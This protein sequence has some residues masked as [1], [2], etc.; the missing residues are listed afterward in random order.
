VQDFLQESKS[1]MVD[2]ILVVSTP[3]SD[4]H[5]ISQH[6]GVDRHERLRI[7]NALRQRGA[8]MAV[9]D[10]EAIPMP[11]Y[12]LDIPRNLAIVTSAVIRSSRDYSGR[13]GFKPENRA[14]EEFCAK[15]FEVEEHALHRV[16]QLATRIS[17]DRRRVSGPP[18]AP[19]MPTFAQN[20]VMFGSQAII[21]TVQ[22]HPAPKRLRK[23]ARPSTAPPGGSDSDSPRRQFMSVDTPNPAH[24]SPNLP[25]GLPKS[26]LEIEKESR[27]RKA[28][29]LKSSSSESISYTALPVV[30]K[31]PMNPSITDISDDTGKRMKGLFRGI[32]RR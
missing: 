22:T 30:K 6:S 32:L 29:R 11:S 28:A 14:L 31:Q 19:L 8:N 25:S 1:A 7:V 16:S 24:L 23:S 13:Q 18:T 15:C 3:V 10:R 27:R 26:H 9:L 12:L 2:Y 21:S 5:T 20:P 4:A 17:S